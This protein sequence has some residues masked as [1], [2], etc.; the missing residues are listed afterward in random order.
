[1]SNLDQNGTW[2]REMVAKWLSKI[3]NEAV[4]DQIVVMC[5]ERINELKNERYISHNDLQAEYTAA[6]QGQRMY[7][8]TPQRLSTK[9]HGRRTRLYRFVY[10]QQYQ[11]RAK[12]LWYSTTKKQGRMEW[13][14]LT[15]STAVRWQLSRTEPKV[16]ARSSGRKTTGA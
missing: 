4:L 3:T 8:E 2:L 7:F 6:S 11:P 9:R 12:R 1:M 15:L 14:Y 13:Q 16:R 5:T 10:F